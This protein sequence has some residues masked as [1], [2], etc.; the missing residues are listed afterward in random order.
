M[1]TKRGNPIQNAASRVK[2][3]VQG[4]DEKMMKRMPKDFQ[5]MHRLRKAPKSK[6]VANEA[7][8]QKDEQNRNVIGFS[9][10]GT[11]RA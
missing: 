8:D 1:A 2:S 9:A 5:D 7:Q 10:Y 4:I 3:A 11:N 6:I